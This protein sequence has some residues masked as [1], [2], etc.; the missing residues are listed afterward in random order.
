MYK[1][2]QLRILDKNIFIDIYNG[3]Q[4]EASTSKS[5]KLKRDRG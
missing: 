5:A 2:A 3:F 1:M 4:G